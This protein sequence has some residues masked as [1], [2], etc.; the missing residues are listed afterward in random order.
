F[1]SRLPNDPVRLL[2]LDRQLLAGPAPT[3]RSHQRRCQAGLLVRSSSELQLQTFRLKECPTGTWTP[4]PIP[5]RV[6]RADRSAPHSG[7][8]ALLP[9]PAFEASTVQV[10]QRLARAV[11][12]DRHSGAPLQARLF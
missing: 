7:I 3:R 8:A 5:G 11:H 1:P 12:E 9:P 4:P 10:L 2:S 6:R